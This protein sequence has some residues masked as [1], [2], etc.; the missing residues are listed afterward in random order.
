MDFDGLLPLDGRQ[1]RFVEEYL[2][3]AR[4]K[5]AAIRAGYSETSAARI[6]W[7]L[8]HDP[9]VAAHIRAAQRDR[10]ERLRISADRIVLE[11]ARLALADIGRIVRLTS[12]GPRLRRPEDI[13]ADESAA[14]REVIRRKDGF[15]LRLYDKTKSLNVLTEMLGVVKRFQTDSAV[16]AEQE[17]DYVKARNKFLEIVKAMRDRLGLNPEASPLEHIAEGVA[18]G[19]EMAQWLAERIGYGPTP[20]PPKPRPR[21]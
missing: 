10:S 18:R 12:K 13:T 5:A 16:A 14:V 2:R 20:R 1:Q 7:R 6:A 3:D 4:P 8:L 9:L 11:H 15:H 19:D 21:A 17:A